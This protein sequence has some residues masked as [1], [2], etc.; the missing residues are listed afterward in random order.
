MATVQIPSEVPSGE[1]GD[2]E[3]VCRLISEGKP[4]TDPAL[5]ERIHQR[6]EQIRREMLA[7]HGMTE[8]AVDLIREARDEG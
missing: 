5:R 2:L 1:I 4:V 3:E 7:K 6:S 8:V